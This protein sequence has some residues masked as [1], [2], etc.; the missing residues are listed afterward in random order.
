[1]ALCETDR[2]FMPCFEC[3]CSLLRDLWASLL[4]SW[5]KAGAQGQGK[6][7]TFVFYLITYQKSSL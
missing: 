3:F 6:R 2:D 4:Q 7:S 1:M 5:G